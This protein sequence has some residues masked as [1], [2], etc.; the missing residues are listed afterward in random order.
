LAFSGTEGRGNSVVG[1]NPW[2]VA[3]GCPTRVFQAGEEDPNA[4]TRLTITTPTRA[5]RAEL[6]LRVERASF[7][8]A[9][10]RGCPDFILHISRLAEIENN[11]VAPALYKPSRSRPFIIWIPSNSPPGTKPRSNKPLTRAPPLLPRAPT[12]PNPFS[13]SHPHSRR[14]FAR[15]RRHLPS[16]PAPRCERRRVLWLSH[17][18]RTPSLRIHWIVGP[19]NGSHPAPWKRRNYRHFDPHN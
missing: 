6:S 14:G 13:L 15:R 18:P 17:V 8:I 2:I 3:A 9:L 4:P 11:N 7:Q 1:H 5:A 16:R 19:A 10:N 12:S